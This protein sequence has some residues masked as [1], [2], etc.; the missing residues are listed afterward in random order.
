MSSKLHMLLNF[1]YEDIIFMCTI[2]LTDMGLERKWRD[3]LHHFYMVE[4]LMLQQQRGGYLMYYNTDFLKKWW[5]MTHY[6][7]REGVNILFK[8]T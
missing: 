8:T 6:I 1:I 2:P 4:K 7:I 3:G 5:Q